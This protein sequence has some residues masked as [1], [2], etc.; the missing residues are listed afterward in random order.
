MTSGN[1][2]WAQIPKGRLST[3]QLWQ[4]GSSNLVMLAMTGLRYPPL[5]VIIRGKCHGEAGA[6]DDAAGAPG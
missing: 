3:H 4:A 1:Q 2:Q 5:A 6:V